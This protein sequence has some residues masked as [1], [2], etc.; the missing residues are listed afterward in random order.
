MHLALLWLCVNVGGGRVKV[1]R[2]GLV[3]SSTNYRCWRGRERESYICTHIHQAHTALHRTIQLNPPTVV[4]VVVRGEIFRPAEV[5]ERAILLRPPV[6]QP[7]RVRE[8]FLLF[9]VVVVA[10]W[11]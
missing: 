10:G 9:V 3:D 8:D 2:C 1:L 4:G 5:G 11:C 6:V 7:V